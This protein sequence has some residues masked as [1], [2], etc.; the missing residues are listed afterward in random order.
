MKIKKI[1]LIGIIGIFCFST[2]GCKGITET[3]GFT[4]ISKEKK[5]NGYTVTEVMDNE[6]RIHYYVNTSY[7]EGFMC[8][9]YKAD[10]TIKKGF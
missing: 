5:I 10:G 4:V 2:T 9:V 6:T 3:K 7:A 8:P 1:L